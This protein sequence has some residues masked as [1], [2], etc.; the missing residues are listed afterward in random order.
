MKR[1]LFRNDGTT[2]EVELPDDIFD[3]GEIII[4]HDGV[5]YVFNEDG[6]IFEAR[7]VVIT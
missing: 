3:Q 1:T 4:E 5:L 7:M 2:R 6:D